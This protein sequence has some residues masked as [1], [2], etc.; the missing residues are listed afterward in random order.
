MDKIIKLLTDTAVSAI[1]IL[2]LSFVKVKCRTYLK[3][4]CKKI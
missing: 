2:I 4:E 3:K 1:V